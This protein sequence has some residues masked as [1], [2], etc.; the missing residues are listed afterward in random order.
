MNNTYYKLNTQETLNVAYFGGSV[1]VGQGSTQN[2]PGASDWFS[3][4]WRAL[5]TDW[6]EEEYG[7]DVIPVNGAIGGTGTKYGAYRAVEHLELASV[8]PDLVFIDFAVNDLYDDLNEPETVSLASRN[9]ETI[10]NTIYEYAPRAD[11]VMVLT[12]NYDTMSGNVKFLTR[13]A[14][15]EIAEAYHIPVID[16]ATP[17]WNLMVEENKG[18][19]PGRSST[20]WNKYISD[21]VHPTDTGYAEYAKTVQTFLQEIF[22][23][24]GGVVPETTVRPY[25]PAKTLNT[26]LVNPRLDTFDGCTFDADPYTTYTLKTSSPKIEN[27]I[28]ALTVDIKGDA[29]TQA[30]AE[31]SFSFKF[32]GTGL[33][34]WIYTHTASSVG[35]TVITGENN[36]KVMVDPDYITVKIDDDAVDGTF[37]LATTGNANHKALEIKSGM[38]DEKHTVTITVH[39]NGQNKA[40]LDLRYVLIDG[41]TERSGIYD[42][43]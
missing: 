21:E 23:K 40:N 7:V 43:K 15:K 18:V 38:K 10:I 17:L 8:V 30:K 39:A 36:Q 9:M 27:P 26:L 22:D 16:V 3:R 29:T 24:N 13:E 19:A 5:T 32:K 11:I 1:T 33:S 28:G 2:I 35:T 20:V 42:V 4:S 37:D 14:H 34:L 6:L 12:G 31:S 25:R 41:D